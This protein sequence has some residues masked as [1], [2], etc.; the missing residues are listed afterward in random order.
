[1]AD[2]KQTPDVLGELL[3][4]G[5]PDEIAVPE[6]AALEAPVESSGAGRTQPRREGR[7]QPS[8]AG[9]KQPSEAGRKQ[10][11]RQ[12]S[13][14]SRKEQWEYLLVSCQ[15]YRG[16]R[17]RYVNGQELVDWMDAPLIHDY[18]DQLGTEGWELTSASAGQSL[19]GL[20]DRHQLYFKRPKR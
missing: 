13:R 9:R 12:T 11:R 20:T 2:R 6:P 10:P 16:W 8:G 5:G 7:K 1:M 3:G 15:E 19:Y 17:P 18:L 4:G 14:S